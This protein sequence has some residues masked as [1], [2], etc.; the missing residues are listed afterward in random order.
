MMS[1]SRFGAPASPWTERFGVVGGRVYG[2]TKKKDELLHAGLA[3][4]NPR[5]HPQYYDFIPSADQ[6]SIPVNDE[7]IDDI[8]VAEEYQRYLLFGNQSWRIPPLNSVLSWDGSAILLG[9][10]QPGDDQLYPQLLRDY[11]AQR[12]EVDESTWLPFFAKDRWYNFD[13]DFSDTITEADGKTWENSAWNVDD[14]RIWNV[15]RFSIEIANR[16]VT[17]LIRDNNKWLGTILYGRVQLWYELYSQPADYQRYIGKKDYRILMN[18]DTEK[19]FC[20][21]L[22][23]LFLGRDVEPNADK[24]HEHITGLLKC[25]V[26]SFLPSTNPLLG[27]TAPYENGTAAHPMYELGHA[28]FKARLQDGGNLSPAVQKQVSEDHEDHWL[29]PYV[30]SEPIRE[31]GRSLEAAIFGGTPVKLS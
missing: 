11:M 17:T 12:I 10:H 9:G 16:I 19:D 20:R 2:L 21:R 14:D 4:S 5:L 22:G 3:P 24:R 8:L 28:L 31:M 7:E 18:P 6:F 27:V 25:L 26:W 1:S 30:D 29:E 15:L 13:Q 23:K